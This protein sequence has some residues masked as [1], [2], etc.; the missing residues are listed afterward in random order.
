MEL[1]FKG[2]TD[3]WIIGSEEINKFGVTELEICSGNHSSIAT[4]YIPDTFKETAEANANLI[5]AAKDL[6]LALAK[7]VDMIYTGSDDEK[8]EAYDIAKSAINKALNGK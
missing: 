2:C 7:C 6:L 4:V 3:E 1:E 5:L 8:A